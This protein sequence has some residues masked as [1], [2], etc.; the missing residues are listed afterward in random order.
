MEPKETFKKLLE[1][2]SRVIR[3]KDEVL[4]L[5][6]YSFFSNGH[7]L[8]EDLPGVGKTTLSKTLAKLLN[9]EFKRIQMTNDLL[10][11]DILGY[12]IFSPGQNAFIM[13]KGPIFTEVLLT[14]ELNRASPK[15]QSALL[16]AME[17]KIVSLEGERFELSP[18]FFVIAT[19]NPYGQIGTFPLPES[20]LDRFCMKIS[21]GTPGME[22]EVELLMG[23]NP[24]STIE[25]IEPIMKLDE[26]SKIKQTIQ[27]VTVSR[28]LS[29]YIVALLQE[30]RSSGQFQPLSPR[31]GIDM[32]QLVR[33]KAF[34]E[35]REF[36]TSDDVIHLAK[37]VFGHRLLNRI[38][39]SVQ[40]GN[41]MAEK[42]L[43]QVKAP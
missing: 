19:Q 23:E 8:I 22:T 32:V 39:G 37:H 4:T 7:L 40:E 11:S 26:I 14:D 2:A 13:E 12:K 5:A 16:E 1:Q 24:V 9:L 3:G 20:Q 34:F 42:L 15:T 29:E 10:P 43:E 30:S 6:I 25:K 33:T 41:A 36:A 35:Q 18:H 17:E 27:S 28:T 21:I 38:Q 31:A